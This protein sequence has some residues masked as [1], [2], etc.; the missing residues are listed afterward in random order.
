MFG[1]V[2]RRTPPCDEPEEGGGDGGT[3][4]ESSRQ[5]DPGTANEEEEE[6]DFSDESSDGDSDLDEGVVVT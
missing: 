6:H 5:L 1:R 4:A 2:A 3:E